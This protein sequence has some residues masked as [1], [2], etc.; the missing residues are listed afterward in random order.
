MTT[1]LHDV[2]IRRIEKLAIPTVDTPDVTDDQVTTFLGNALKLGY[3]LTRPVVE[4]LAATTTET[5]EDVLRAMRASRGAQYVYVPMYP[6][7]PKQVALATDH[8]LFSVRMSHYFGGLIG[9]RFLPDFVKEAR[10]ELRQIDTVTVLHLAAEDTLRHLFTAIAGS[11]QP[12]SEQDRNDLLVLAEYATATAIDIK[13]NAAW[14]AVQFD[15]I[16][17]S[18]NFHTVTD[19]LR[20]AVA[21]SDGDTSLAEQ[22]KFTLS[23][24]QRRQVLSLLDRVIQ[25]SGNVVDDFLK[26]AE[27]W[28]RLAHALRYHDYA[29]RYPNAANMLKQV[30]EETL[31]VGF[32]AAVERAI[33]DRA[34]S[35]VLDL[36]AQRPGVFAR[37]LHELV[38]K[39]P[40]NVDIIMERF[41]SVGRHVS[42]TVLVQ[43]WNFFNSATNDVLA[44]RLVHIKMA[45]GT[46]KTIAI[47]NTLDSNRDYR[48]VLDGI[49]A[50]FAQVKTDQTIY[51]TKD[52]TQYA[53]PLGV[54][55]MSSGS[56]QIARGSRVRLAPEDQDKNILRM[57]MHW[58][59]GRETGRVDL[60]LSMY[61]VSEDFQ[62]TE[63]V[64]Y[65]NQRLGG[66]AYHSGDI[67]SAPEGASEFID[68]NLHAALNAGYRY[69]IPSV[70]NYTG[71]TFDLVNEA[72]AGFMLREN[73]QSGEIY[74]PK[75]VR[76]AYELNA[77]VANSVP[78]VFDMETREML[79]LDSTIRPNVYANYNVANN[80]NM[81]NILL[82]DAVYGASMTVHDLAANLGVIVDNESDAD[83]IIDPSDFTQCATILQLEPAKEYV[84]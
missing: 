75:T 65:Y 9:E 57:F 17:W 68:V 7:F 37:R 51:F 10:P 56:Q 29:N 30:Q 62:Q 67:T 50:V 5:L 47:D 15:D 19:V 23:R 27:R 11:A 38:R 48:A 32:N 8:D 26:Y 35:R 44:H 60:D 63:T 73:M 71:Q 81:F 45:H 13:E 18:D 4:R 74:D 84:S 59:D 34:L 41:V 31:G 72:L 40:E 70:Y 20:F 69:A 21:L 46:T 49:A 16:D 14:V 61:F 3:V 55:S 39:F 12:Y 79:W 28:K 2:T 25:S 22:T 54:R 66:V 78:F 83:L 24:P 80:V 1:S 6:N 52:A 33:Q 64:A 58:K 42:L 82:Q 43:L 77:A 53:V 36:L 76:H